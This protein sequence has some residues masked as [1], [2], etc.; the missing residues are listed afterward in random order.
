M[1]YDADVNV[2]ECIM[3]YAFIIDQDEDDEN[4]FIRYWKNLVEELMRAIQD[5]YINNKKEPE[6]VEE[7]T[8]RVKNLKPVSIKGITIQTN[9]I[10]IHG[11]K[12][13]VEFNYCGRITR[14]ELGDIIFILSVVYNGKKYFEKLTINQVKKSKGVSWSFGNTGNTGN[15]EQLYLLSRFPTFRGVK[16]SLIPQKHYNLPNFSG[17]LGT[18]GLLYPPGDFA[19]IS[20]KKLEDF[21]LSS[22]RKTIQLNDLV[23]LNTLQTTMCPCHILKGSFYVLLLDIGLHSWECNS[24]FWKYCKHS[25]FPCCNL[26]ILGNCCT[27]SNAYEFSHRYLIGHVGELI[28]AKGLPYNEN[29]LKFLQDLFSVLK[30]KAEREGLNQILDFIKSY[31]KYDYK[32]GYANAGGGSGGGGGGED[33]G[34][35]GDY[36]GGGFGIIHTII[37]LG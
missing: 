19:T 21:L 33:R 9:S 34:D 30:K 20:S 11:K 17:C 13:E 16:S 23:G 1:W 36:E 22:N 27:A 7:M 18:H 29:A 35:V 28:Y 2:K 24:Y 8:E 12:S 6:I 31:Y 3:R 26:P 10:F 5:G 4:E 32:Y 25:P 14:R 37:N 15:K